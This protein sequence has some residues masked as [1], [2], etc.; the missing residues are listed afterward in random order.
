MAF[1]QHGERRKPIAIGRG[2]IEKN[3][4]DIRIVFQKPHR[5]RAV[6][7]FHGDGLTLELGEHC[8]QRMPDQD[9]IID[10]ENLPG[11]FSRRALHVLGLAEK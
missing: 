10:H 6:E 11:I 8:A 2:K 4:I 9:M 3:E 5:F 1:A 7:R